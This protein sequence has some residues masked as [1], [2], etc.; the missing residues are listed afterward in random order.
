MRA[1]FAR[2][3][4]VLLATLSISWADAAHAEDEAATVSRP[5]KQSNIGDSISQGFD[6]NSVPL[7]HP[8]LS[9]VQG[10]DDRIDS[11]YSRQAALSASFE[12]EPE[13]VTGAELV[14]G[15]DNFPAQASRV[16]AQSTVP[17]EVFL[18]LGANDL[19]N[20]TRANGND[21]TVNLYSLDTT[22]EFLRAGIDQLVACMPR[23]GLVQVMSMP[24]VDY[25]YE[26]GHAKS[27][28]C[29]WGVWPIAGVCRIVTGESSASKRAQ[30]GTFVDAYNQLLADEVHAYD[31]NANG[32][33]DKAIRFVTDWMGSS[34]TGHDSTSIGTFHFNENDINGVDCFHPNEDAQGRIACLAWAA[35]PFG[36]GSRAAC[37]AR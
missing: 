32:K 7:D 5:H 26:A 22:R 20:R 12:Q 8:S 35:N 18:L 36:S 4:S 30:L 31:T 19:C 11:L 2:I 23:G 16:C 24:R 17:D 28:W 34:A 13:S 21:A 37:V 9:W 29:N 6:A 15:D 1:A 10:T 3:G 14:G 27:F 33:N 25:L